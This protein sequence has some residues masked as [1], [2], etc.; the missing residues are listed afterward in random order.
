MNRASRLFP[1]AVS[2]GLSACFHV[3]ERPQELR[4]AEIQVQPPQ[5]AQVVPPA[6]PE[7]KKKLPKNPCW[8]PDEPA[9]DMLESTREIL[10]EISCNAAFWVDYRLS[11]D[12]DP[13]VHR[14]ETQGYVELSGVYSEFEGF[15]HRLR[16]K[17]RVDLPNTRQRLSAFI[18][19]E[20]EDEA[21]EGRS[22]NF[23]QRSQFPSLND[24]GSWLAGLGYSFPGNDRLRTGIRIGAASLS[25]PRLFVRA[26][27]HY[28]AYS[29]EQNLVYL[30]LAPFWSTRDGW[31]TS[32][33]I[34][35]NHLIRKGLLLRQTNRGTIN[36]RIRGFDWYSAVILYQNL[37][38]QRGVAWQMF[39]RGQTDEPEPLAEYGFRAVYRYPMFDERMFGEI[40]LGYSW[41]RIDPN[42]PR[43]GSSAIGYGLTM[44]FGYEPH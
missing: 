36:Q 40:L 41:P 37:P 10:F 26:H 6:E 25:D 9:E 44:P 7:P 15:N 43:E 29:D 23:S 33:Q 35:L 42:L 32:G 38:Q 39:G 28:T 31:G 34:D 30:K 2:L 12:T 11:G 8:M 14:D 18:E 19:R 21:I 4:A 3:S 1:V 22:E 27:A 16:A 17:V 5:S 13:K 20:D 24:N